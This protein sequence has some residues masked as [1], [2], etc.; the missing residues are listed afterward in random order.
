MS[1]VF[2]C[3]RDGMKKSSAVL[4][5]SL[6]FAILKTLNDSE[7]ASPEHAKDVLVILRSAFACPHNCVKVS[8]DRSPRVTLLLLEHLNEITGGKMWKEIEETKHFIQE[9]TSQ[10]S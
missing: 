7:M 8:D 1:S 4:A 5:I 3:T 9:Q 6:L 2:G 10:A